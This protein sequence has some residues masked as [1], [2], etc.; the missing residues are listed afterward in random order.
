MKLII[1]I[2]V[3]FNLFIFLNKKKLKAMLCFSLL[4]LIYWKVKRCFSMSWNFCSCSNLLCQTFVLDP[5]LKNKCEYLNLCKSLNK[6]LAHYFQKY[7]N[8]FWQKH[9]IRV[10]QLKCRNTK[11]KLVFKRLF[12]SF[13]KNSTMPFI[14]NK[15]KTNNF[16]TLKTIIDYYNK[17]R[18]SP[19]IKVNKQY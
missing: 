2:S 12:K 4:L 3:L 16:S 1:Y 17:H 7:D 19:Y 15:L 8:Y 13:L 9:R 18:W 5:L 10:C 14:W 11:T 6:T